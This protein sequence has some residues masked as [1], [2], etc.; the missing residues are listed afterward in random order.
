MVGDLRE[1]SPSTAEIGNCQYTTE[2]LDEDY[3]RNAEDGLHG[4]IEAA[5]AIEEYWMTAIKN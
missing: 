1:T 5:I 2:M 3:P 4:N